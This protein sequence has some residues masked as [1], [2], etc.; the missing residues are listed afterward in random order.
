MSAIR[1]LRQLSV[2]SSRTVAARSTPAAAR[3]R[4]PTLAARVAL[5]A[6]RAFSVSARSFSEG[7]SQY[8][9]N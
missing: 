8:P 7:S 5:P 1:A 3:L 9:I 4:L 2:S 6:T